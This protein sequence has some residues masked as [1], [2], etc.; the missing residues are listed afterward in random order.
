M[1]NKKTK[2]KI[3]SNKSKNSLG[4]TVHLIE[5]FGYFDSE[6]TEA[7]SEIIAYE[8]SHARK[9]TQF[10]FH[11]EKVEHASSHYFA[12]LVECHQT[13]RKLKSKLIL[14]NTNEK[15]LGL[16]ETLGLRTFFEYQ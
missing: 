3:T 7:I 8:I 5:F 10:V 6:G 2:A 12:L 1:K 4:N 13:L 9:N 11:L 15:I 14:T 16:M